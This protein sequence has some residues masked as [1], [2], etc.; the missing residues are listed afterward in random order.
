MSTLTA[1]S[2]DTHLNNEI[3]VKP[4]LPI[5]NALNIISD[6]KDIL[7]QQLS[8]NKKLL[9]CY[10]EYKEKN[11]NLRTQI[12]AFY[13]KD[14]DRDAYKCSIAIWKHCSHLEDIWY[15]SIEYSTINNIDGV[16]IFYN[17]NSIE[18]YRCIMAVISDSR[19]VYCQEIGKRVCVNLMRMFIMKNLNL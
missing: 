13:Q 15:G 8:E 4:I 19:R 14:L 17:S 3:L 12:I 5:N 9:K 10:S 6:L 18:I 16:L 2:Q 11:N 7:L 1:L